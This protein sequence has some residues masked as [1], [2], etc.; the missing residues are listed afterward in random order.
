MMSFCLFCTN[1]NSHKFTKIIMHIITK[2][3]ATKAQFF[4]LLLK[5]DWKPSNKSSLEARCSSKNSLK[6]AFNNMKSHWE[7]MT[8]NRNS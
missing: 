8:N 3:V 2:T 1:Q 5:N 4:S 7:A 6:A